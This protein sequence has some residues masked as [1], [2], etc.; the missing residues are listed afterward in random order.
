MVRRY[1]NR[2]EPSQIVLIEGEVWPHLLLACRNRGTSPCV[3]STPACRPAPPG[4]SGGSPHGCGRSIGLLEP[5]RSRKPEMRRSGRPLV[6]TAARIHATG[7]LK[8]DP[9]S[10]ASDP[11][12]G[13]NSSKCSMPSDQG[14]PVVLAASTHAGEDAWI[15]GAIREADPDALAGHRAAP[16]RT[17]AEVKADLEQAGFLVRL[18][19][20]FRRLAATDD[21]APRF[22]H[23][24]HRRAAGLDGACG[25]GHHRQKLP[26]H[27]RAESLRGD[28]GRKA[29]GL[30]PAH[31]ELPTAR[32]PAHRG[33]R[34]HFRP[35]SKPDF[36]TPFSAA[37]DPAKAAGD[38]PP[39]HPQF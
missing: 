34:L 11:R 12:G 14:R 7:S 36:R 17:A 10:G 19:S 16:C 6:S 37:L 35:R 3:W 21:R 20:S 9:G 15:A 23:R 39:A 29:G 28:P 32:P 26:R 25:R 33:R 8:F 27:R 31:G 5:W 22:R 4:G 18:R 13:R 30:R 1:L 2:F 24:L 38:D